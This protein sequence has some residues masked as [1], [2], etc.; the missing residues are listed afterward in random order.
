MAESI[1]KRILN[2][3]LGIRAPAENVQAEIKKKKILQLYTSAEDKVAKK[4]ILKPK[5]SFVLKKIAKKSGGNSLKKK[6]TT[7]KP[8]PSI[9]SQKPKKNKKFVLNKIKKTP[10]KRTASSEI[11]TSRKVKPAKK[12]LAVATR[13]NAENRKTKKL[14]GIARPLGVS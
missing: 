9:Q 10:K 2:K 4:K 5:R 3:F 7:P 11:K 14:Q 13:K 8:P 1:V 6:K 12:S